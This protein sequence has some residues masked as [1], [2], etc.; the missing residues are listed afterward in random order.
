MNTQ[1]WMPL[2]YVP[3][4][5]RNYP[6]ALVQLGAI[7]NQ[8]IELG[9]EIQLMNPVSLFTGTYFPIKITGFRDNFVLALSRYSSVRT[10]AEDYFFSRYP[11]DAYRRLPTEEYYRLYPEEQ[12][13]LPGR[14][15]NPE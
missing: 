12:N 7:S 11:R 5:T 3:V 13:L 10:Q 4:D 9:Q 8:H 15:I 14:V 2:P 1:V 6:P